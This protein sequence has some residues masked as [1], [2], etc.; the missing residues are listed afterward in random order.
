MA[1]FLLGWQGTGGRG[2]DQQKANQRAGAGDRRVESTQGS[3][4]SLQSIPM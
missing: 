2:G 4:F 1:S 3:S